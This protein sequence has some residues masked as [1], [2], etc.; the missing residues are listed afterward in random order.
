[1]KKEDLRQAAEKAWEAAALAV[2]DYA[3]WKE[4]K[5]L[6]S[7][8][9]LW[10]YSRVI[11]EDLGTWVLEVW[12]QA[13]GMHTCFYEGWCTKEHVDATLKFIEKLVNAIA[14]MVLKDKTLRTS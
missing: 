4:G 5:H 1:M 7:H 9:E 2:K 14:E 10:E 12:N 13:S 3:Y 6:S 8:G 11:S